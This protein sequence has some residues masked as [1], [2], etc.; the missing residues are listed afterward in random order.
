MNKDSFDALLEWLD[1]DRDKAGRRYEVIRGGLIRMFVSH[2]L[3]DAEHYA[4]ETVDR[5]I[6]RLP[7]IREGYVDDPAR[8]FRGVARNI[9]REARRR[10]EIATD[11]LPECL[12]L[13]PGN[14]E[15]VECLSQCLKLLPPDKHDL[16]LDYHLYDGRD[17]IEHHRQM[18]SELSITVG[19]LRTRA[20]H[21]RVA[22][23]QC[24][25]NCV[26]PDRNKT[27]SRGH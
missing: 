21:I 18:A 26:D 5:V 19:A 12:P 22:L 7:D 24:I 1:P 2:G 15:M 27:D 17:K 6:N 13:K 20:H 11:E 25:L 23:E 4:D 8:Y 14:R 16:I 9:V 10:R 3:A